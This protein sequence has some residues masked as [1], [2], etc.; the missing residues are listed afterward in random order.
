M[1]RLLITLALTFTSN[2]LAQEPYAATSGDVTLT[3][4]AWSTTIP[5]SVTSGWRPIPATGT[6]FTVCGANSITPKR[7]IITHSS[8]GEV[9]KS[10]E[11][12]A[13]INDAGNGLRCGNVLKLISRSDIVNVSVV[14]SSAEFSAH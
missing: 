14:T 8:N 2:A 5:A 1:K 10:V 6:W 9:V 7:I 13:Y 4:F 11:E 12:F 3:M